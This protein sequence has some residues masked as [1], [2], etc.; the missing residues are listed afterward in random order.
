M[1]RFK[2][3]TLLKSEQNNKWCYYTFKCDKFSCVNNIVVG[4]REHFEYRLIKE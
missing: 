1:Q 4:V 2:F 3:P